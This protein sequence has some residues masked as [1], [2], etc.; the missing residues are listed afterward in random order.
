MTET[1]TQRKL[2]LWHVRDGSVRWLLDNPERNLEYAFVPPNGG[3]VVAVE[4]ENAGIRT[5]F[6]DPETGNETGLPEIPGNLVPL[7][8][9]GE[10]HWLGFYYSARRPPD[11]VRL[12]LP[13]GEH[14]SLTGLRDLSPLDLDGLAPAEDFRWKSVDGLE[15]QGLVV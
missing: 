2:G 13:F 14:E 10:D 3:P 8:P 6:L 15:I 5:S 11:L 4:V 1:G 9:T 12:D 7:A